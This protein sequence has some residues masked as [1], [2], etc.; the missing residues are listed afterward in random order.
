MISWLLSLHMRLRVLFSN[1]WQFCASIDFYQSAIYTHLVLNRLPAHFCTVLNFV[2]DC[3]VSCSFHVIKMNLTLGQVC[4]LRIVIVD[5]KLALAI[6]TERGKLAQRFDHRA[7]LAFE[8]KCILCI[9]GTQLY[10]ILGLTDQFD[11]NSVSECVRVV[12]T[13][14]Y[15]S[16]RKTAL[17]PLIIYSV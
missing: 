8:C 16:S 2:C 17:W 12:Q 6:W 3:E 7:Q 9:I 13:T 10:S 4:L 1:Y 15:N 11:E 5:L 14:P